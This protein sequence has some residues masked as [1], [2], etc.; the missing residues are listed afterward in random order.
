M[1]LE[2]EFEYFLEHQEELV[3]KYD[4]RQVVIKSG[5]ILGDYETAGEAYFETIEQGHK[6]GTFLIQ[7][8]LPGEEAYTATITN[9]VFA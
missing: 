8:A 5:E 4:G 7:V 1:S 3:A 9:A 2:K 6:P